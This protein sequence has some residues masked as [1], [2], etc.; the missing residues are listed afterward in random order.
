VFALSKKKKKK[1]ERKKE[2]F[3]IYGISRFKVFVVYG[4]S[5]FNLLKWANG[6]SLNQKGN[7]VV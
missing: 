6:I 3:V 5:R 2:V 7:A 4:I 1:K